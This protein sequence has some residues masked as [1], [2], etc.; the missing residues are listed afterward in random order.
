MSLVPVS[1]AGF[2]ESAMG[3]CVPMGGRYLDTF[4]SE[5]ELEMTFGDGGFLGVA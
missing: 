3:Y 4:L 2:T 1:S 5:I